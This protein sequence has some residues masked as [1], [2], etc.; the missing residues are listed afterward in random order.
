MRP[1]TLRRYAADA[2]FGDVELPPIEAESF[3]FYL[4]SS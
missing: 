3:R 4:L 1:A 2:G